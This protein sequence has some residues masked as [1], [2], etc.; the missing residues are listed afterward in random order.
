VNCTNED[1]LIDGDILIN[2]SGFLWINNSNI[3]I[4]LNA[5]KLEVLDG[6]KIFIKKD[7]GVC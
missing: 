2:N 1:F 6:G 5:Q 7:S 4:N 3:S